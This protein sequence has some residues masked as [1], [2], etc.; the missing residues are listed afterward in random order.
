MADRLIVCRVP[1]DYPPRAARIQYSTIRPTKR[2]TLPT[3]RTP[4][5]RPRCPDITYIP[6]ADRTGTKPSDRVGPRWPRAS[7]IAILRRRLHSRRV[8]TRTVRSLLIRK[9]ADGPVALG[10]HH[11]EYSLLTKIPGDS[12]RRSFVLGMAT[13]PGQG[14]SF[15][16]NALPALAPGGD[17]RRRG[18]STT[19]S[20]KISLS[21]IVRSSALAFR[22]PADLISPAEVPVEMNAFKSKQHRWAKGSIQTCRKRAA[23]ILRANC[24][25]A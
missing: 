20:L 15:N 3:G 1:D 6:R 21:A 22:F 2:A 5:G 12:A 10:P 4:A 19:R 25:C 8:P 13:K 24:P 9:I 18:C 7:F 17:R 23:R 11:Q 14:C 16:F